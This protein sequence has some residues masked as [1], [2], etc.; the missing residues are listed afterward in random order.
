MINIQ[1]CINIKKLFNEKGLLLLGALMTLV[2]LFWSLNKGM[3][4]SDE[5]YYLFHLKQPQSAIGYS[6]WYLFAQP[7]FQYDTIVL[8]RIIIVLIMIITNLFLA[9]SIQYFFSNKLF[10][11]Y[12]LILIFAQF[13]TTSPV[14]Y[15]P[16]YLTFNQILCSLAV[17]FF[18][19]Y[20][21]N[22]GI[23]I[24]VLL[25]FVFGIMMFNIPTSIGLFL[26]MLVF[27]FFTHKKIS[28]SINLILYVVL[29]MLLWIGLYFTTIE[30]YSLFKINLLESI[31]VI[32][33][34]DKHNMGG[35]LKWH[36][37]ILVYFMPVLVHLFLKYFDFKNIF[38]SLF[39]K[40]YFYLILSYTIYFAI[41]N[42]NYNFIMTPL[43]LLIID[44]IFD[45][46]SKK[47]ITF[48]FF[49]MILPYFCTLGTDVNLIYR[50][51][52]YSS[53]LF[54][55]LYLTYQNSNQLSLNG[56]KVLYLIV[57]INFTSYPFRECW[58]GYKLVEQNI[59]YV[60]GKETLYLDQKRYDQLMSVSKEI[61]NKKVF[62]TDH[63]LYGYALLSNAKLD[64][65][66]FRKDQDLYNTFINL[67]PKG[68]ILNNKNSKIELT[69]KENVIYFE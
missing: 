57:L 37:K 15:S 30:Q 25:G 3:L 63:R 9:K 51:A 69:Q 55:A 19:V 36:L 56:F 6:K 8:N 31:N 35:L 50:S 26:P 43:Y 62:I 58:E 17:A 28:S 59:P 45:L 22:K 12:F 41:T 68:L 24:K 47:E 4:F 65:L 39:Y 14:G 40:I 38:N 2:I 33:N 48:L 60:F 20:S 42:G 11:I 67:N 52:S 18:L 32:A 16:S 61:K 5:A 34:D 49:L 46:K 54:I 23:Y 64:N 10:L 13:A 29:G 7:F 66:I 44:K 53:F 21:K 1:N 27:D